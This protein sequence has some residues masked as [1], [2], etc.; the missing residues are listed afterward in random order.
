[1]VFIYLI[2]NFQVYEFLSDM[3]LITH[4]VMFG[5]EHS[6]MLAQRVV[7]LTIEEAD[8]HFVEWFK[9]KVCHI[10]SCKIS[11]LFRR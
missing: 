11:R 8:G 7:Q 10:L 2:I 3:I 4:F 1:M 5:R 6:E 9:E